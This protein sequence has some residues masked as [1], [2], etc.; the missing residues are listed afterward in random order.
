MPLEAGANA[1]VLPEGRDGPCLCG[2]GIAMSARLDEILN[3]KLMKALY[4]CRC[5]GRLFFLDFLANS[6]VNLQSLAVTRGW[7][8]IILVGIYAI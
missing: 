6:R 1:L 5:E 2:A 7:Y 8:V 4:A 3:P